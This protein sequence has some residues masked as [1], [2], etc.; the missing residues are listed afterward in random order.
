MINAR[1]AIILHSE[2]LKRN[3]LKQLITETGHIPYCFENIS[4][5]LDNLNTLSPDLILIGPYSLTKTSR[6]VNFVKTI[7][8][9][10]PLLLLGANGAV[11]D[12]VASNRFDTVQ[13]AGNNDRPHELK[14]LINDVAKGQRSAGR[15]GSA[16]L[17]GSSPEMIKLRKQCAEISQS[18][19]PVLVQ[20][21]SGT[22]KDLVARTLHRWSR[23]A[24]LP[25]IKINLAD[26]TA[27]PLVSG[28]LPA[29]KPADADAGLQVLDRLFSEDQ[30]GTLLLDGVE[31]IPAAFQERLRG[32]LAEAAGIG[33]GSHG[34][35]D[36]RRR[37]IASTSMHIETLVENNHFSKPLFYGLSVFKIEIPPLRKHPEDIS[38]LVDYFADIHCWK[39]TN[40]IC[41]I[42]G[43]A[44][45]Q[46][47]AHHWPGNQAEL[48]VVVEKYIDSGFDDNLLQSVG[49]NSVAPNPGRC[50]PG[51]GWDA[52]AAALSLMDPG[53]EPISMKG[54]CKQLVAKT[55]RKLIK[56]ALLHNNWN[57]K[58]AARMLDISYRS[59]LNKIK[60]YSLS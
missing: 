19:E 22:G 34:Q 57:R 38:L 50:R 25:L 44:K 47:Q 21:E 45:Q 10:I 52:G 7:D 26:L 30:Q 32:H 12:F 17:V 16:L 14:T 53:T 43:D 42:G 13:F 39:L 54:V 6:F 51:A 3:R 33:T 5:C 23:M 56:R 36:R 58:K 41:D 2:P 4:I 9:G 49:R 15:V 59:L 40:G 24:D 28:G 60:E 46:L 55:E 8:A 48:G 27:A 1:N 35:L 29:I 20:G 11:R 37:I 31:H 18:Q